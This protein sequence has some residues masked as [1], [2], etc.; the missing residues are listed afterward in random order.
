MFSASFAINIL[1]N[2]LVFVLVFLVVDYVLGLLAAPDPIRLVVRVIMA[3]LA[4]LW[5]LRFFV[6]S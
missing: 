3:L 2:L 5:L 4:L 6:V 1:I